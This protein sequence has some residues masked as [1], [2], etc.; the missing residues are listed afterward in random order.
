VLTCFVLL[1]IHEE[2]QILDLLEM[3]RRRNG[4]CS[5]VA[6]VVIPSVQLDKVGETRGPRQ[7]LGTAAR[8]VADEARVGALVD[9]EANGRTGAGHGPPPRVVGYSKG[10]SWPFPSLRLLDQCLQTHP[11]PQSMTVRKK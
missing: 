5:L 10:E 6:D 8:G 1:P 11:A 3:T 2:R 9:G 7:G 4:R